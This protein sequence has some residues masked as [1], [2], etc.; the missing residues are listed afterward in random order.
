MVPWVLALYVHGQIFYLNSGCLVL[1]GVEVMFNRYGE[2]GIG[3]S[4]HNTFIYLCTMHEHSAIELF[5]GMG[6]LAVGAG[7]Q[8]RGREGGRE[9]SRCYV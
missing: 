1:T 9:G 2:F 7:G 4:T 6:G 3:N 5:S 8:E